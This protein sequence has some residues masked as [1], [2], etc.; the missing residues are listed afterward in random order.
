MFAFKVHFF[1]LLFSSIASDV[2]FLKLL[3]QYCA[4]SLDCQLH[5]TGSSNITKTE[6]KWDECCGKCSCDEHCG[7]SQSC[8]FAEENDRYLRTHGKECIDSF[9]GDPEYFQMY[10]GSGFVMVTQCPDKNEECKYRNGIVNVNPVESASSEVFIN[11]KCARCNNISN[12][13]RWNARI[14]SRGT[15]F[16][17]FR[18]IEEQRINTETILYEPPTNFNYPTCYGSF[19]TVNISECPNDLYKD[20]CTSTVLPFITRSGPYQNVFCY[21]CDALHLPTC[22]ISSRTFPGTL[23]LLLN[24]KLD[25]TTIAAYFSRENLPT[26]KDKCQEGFMPHPSRVRLLHLIQNLSNFNLTLLTD[27]YKT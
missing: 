14:L 19:V 11:K 7:Q 8:C 23:S 6:N 27:L 18:N 22:P 12:F 13:V 21:L 26:D 16:Y 3:N 10:G 24:N 17:S 20:A 25:P 9:I 2:N 15:S 1:I 4:I 5:N